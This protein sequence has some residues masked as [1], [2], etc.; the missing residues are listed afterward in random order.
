LK[1]INI[2]LGCFENYSFDFE[3]KNW[4]IIGPSLSGKTLIL[5]LLAF[6]SKP[7]SG[8]VVNPKKTAFL[9]EGLGFGTIVSKSYLYYQ[10]RYFSQDADLSPTVGEVLQGKAKPLGTIHA[11]SVAQIENR[12]NPA[13][14]EEV[15][16]KLGIF[17]LLDRNVTSLSNGETKRTQL[18]LLLLQ[19]PEVLLLNNPLSGLDSVSRQNFIETIVQLNGL[20]IIV[21]ANEPFGKIDNHLILNGLEIKPS[22]KNYTLPLTEPLDF[23]YAFVLRNVKVFYQE[24]LLKGVNW[25][26]KKNEKWALSGANGSGKSSLI[27]MLLADH[28]QRFA[29]DIEMFDSK[30]LNMWEIKKNIG[31]VSPEFVLYFNAT[32]PVWKALASGL[33]DTVG[34]FKKL[35]FSEEESLNTMMQLFEIEHL[36]NKPLYALTNAE[37]RMVFIARAMIKNPAL[38]ILDEPC[39]GLDNA[40]IHFIKSLID[41]I[42]SKNEITIVFV[43]HVF[44][45]IPSCI[46]KFARIEN[47][48]LVEV[49][50]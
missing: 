37:K 3:N 39:Q 33:F 14:L 42:A 40:Q 11:S 21:A 46:N 49:N 8:Q 20:Q 2:T 44:A 13:W 12:Y 15:C 7:I 48:Y 30:A 27:A 24:P 16:H 6:K 19:K 38:L 25:A 32:T 41:G 9:G 5:K 26:V 28:P 45:E 29:N 34:L 31:F 22:N 17:H 35:S 36:R 50:S 10:Q 18:A 23:R 43:T 4:L 47:G 1:L